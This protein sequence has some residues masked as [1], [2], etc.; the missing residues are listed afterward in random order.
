MLFVVKKVLMTCFLYHQEVM[1]TLKTSIDPQQVNGATVDI[2]VDSKPGS[3]DIVEVSPMVQASQESETARSQSAASNTSEVKEPTDD[4]KPA[5]KKAAKPVIALVAAPV[6]AARVS[7]RHAQDEVVLSTDDDMS[8]GEIKMVRKGKY[9]I[10][11][12][13][14]N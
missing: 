14:V 2:S 4:D 1:P 12:N 8:D 3:P 10:S 9:F 5:V 11:V 13:K 7:T 6:A